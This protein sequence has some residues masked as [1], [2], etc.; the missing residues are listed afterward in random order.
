[1]ATAPHNTTNQQTANDAPSA[2]PLK[3]TLVEAEPENADNRRGK[4]QNYSRQR[5][6][7]PSTNNWRSGR[8][9]GRGRS[10]QGFSG[11]GRGGGRGRG[12][13][14][15]SYGQGRG[16]GFGGGYTGGPM[17]YPNPA[18]AAP[19]YAEQ[20][21]YMAEMAVKQ[22][23][24]YFTVENLC[25]DIFMRSYMDE[26]GYI[27]IAFVANFPGVARF[28][29]D[30]E[31]I[32]KGVLSSELMEVDEEN[33]TMRMREG[34]QV[35]LLPNQATGRQGVQRYV[36]IALSEANGEAGGKE[37]PATEHCEDVADAE[38]VGEEVTGV[39]ASGDVGVEL[40]GSEGSTIAVGQGEQANAQQAEHEDV[41]SVE[42]IQLEEHRGEHRN[43]ST[44]EGLA[45]NVCA[46]NEKGLPS[47][48]ERKTENRRQK[49]SKAP[50]E[51][52]GEEP[53]IASC[54]V[55][56]GN[57]TSHD[58]SK[59]ASAVAADLSSANACGM[60]KITPG[61]LIEEEPK[62]MEGVKE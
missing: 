50:G 12:G 17:Y 18:Y 5:N 19:S 41:L 47:K 16:R 10:G 7:G 35:W 1:M 39:G 22:I 42:G 56:T 49:I 3:W 53:G 54:G 48:E 62:N 58:Q 31:D 51:D 34:W 44:A 13:R 24:F 28:G 26:E 30:L 11:G 32:K 2:A 38:G 52:I 33:E 8:E 20:K 61:A 9:P 45:K 6:Q 15:H 29:V 4:P 27:P 59:H 60:E 23:E 37:V 40:C 46:G 36:K 21:R 43:N 25:R 57:M 14:S 55:A